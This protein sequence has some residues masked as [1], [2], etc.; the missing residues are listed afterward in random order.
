MVM[1]LQT[2]TCIIMYVVQATKNCIV[3]KGR[4]EHE[5]MEASL[6]FT[7]RTTLQLSKQ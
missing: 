6:Q 1:F 2:L 3:E 7:P 5:Q 4:M